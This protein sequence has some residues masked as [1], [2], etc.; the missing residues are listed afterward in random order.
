MRESRAISDNVSFL[1]CDRFLHVKNPLKAERMSYK[2]L[3]T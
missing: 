2:V 1:R 3:H